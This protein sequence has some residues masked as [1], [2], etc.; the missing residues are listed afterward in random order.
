MSELRSAASSRANSC[1]YFSAGILTKSTKLQRDISKLLSRLHTNTQPMMFNYWDLN[2][3]H[4]WDF[5]TNQSILL[6]SGAMSASCLKH[7]FNI[8]FLTLQILWRFPEQFNANDWAGTRTLLRPFFF[9]LGFSMVVLHLSLISCCCGCSHMDSLIIAFPK[10]SSRQV[11][12]ASVFNRT[13]ILEI[14]APQLLL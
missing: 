1:L 9:L 14:C 3:T 4:V 13:W 8:L 6:M 2:S 5:K 11:S 12:C 7:W 10:N